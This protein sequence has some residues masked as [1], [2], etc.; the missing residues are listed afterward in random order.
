MESAP[1]KDCSTYQYFK[2]WSHDFSFEKDCAIV[3]HWKT[4]APFFFTRKKMALL[5][6][7]G[8]RWSLCS[9]LEKKVAPFFFTGKKMTLLF[10]TGKKMVHCSSLEKVWR[11]CSALKKRCR[12]C[13]SQFLDYKR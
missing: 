8:K 2:N 12:I 11:Y 6:C 9:A 1:A 7:T 4:E 13:S 5:F 10:S 3:L